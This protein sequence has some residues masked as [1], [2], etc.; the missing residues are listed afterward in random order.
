VIVAVVSWDLTLPTAGSLKEKRMVV[1]SLK[2]RLRKHFNVSVAET[3]Y[4]ELW[5]RTRLTV[6]LVASD[7]SNVD[8]MLDRMDRLVE[9]EARAVIVG[10]E[11]EIL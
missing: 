9:G 11:R 1:R 6:A 7:A 3:A 5:G 2:D 10:V 8:S 4:Q